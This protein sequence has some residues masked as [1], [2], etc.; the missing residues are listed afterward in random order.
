MRVTF[1]RD[2]LLCPRCCGR[3]RHVATLL[4]AASARAV[5]AHLGLPVRGPPWRPPANRP[6]GRSPTTSSRP[7][8]Q[9]RAG[10]VSGGTQP[11]LHGRP[12][13]RS[14]RGRRGSR[15]RAVCSP[16]PHGIDAAQDAQNVRLRRPG[17][18]ACGGRREGRGRWFGLS[19]GESCTRDRKRRWTPERVCASP[20]AKADAWDVGRRV[21][22][23]WLPFITFR[24]AERIP[25]RHWV[26]AIRAGL[27]ESLSAASTRPRS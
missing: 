15:K 18:G 23:C 27:G 13:S 20:C 16:P 3:L 1:E 21:L 8:S 2:V 9:A 4:D 19:P 14:P 11:E 25:A 6:S 12:A 10:S 22:S 5:L 24:S 7:R 17:G 26:P